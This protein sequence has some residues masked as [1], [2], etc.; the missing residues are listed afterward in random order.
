MDEF[1]CSIGKK[2]AA[3]IDVTSNPLLSKE[4]SMNDDERTFN[5]RTINEREI[6]EAMSKM[7]LKKS[8]GN[9]SISGYSEECFSFNFQN[10]SANFQY[11]Y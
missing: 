3:D 6:Q 10:S 2:L 11:F 5:F 9:D 7:K 8:F 4:I 1:F